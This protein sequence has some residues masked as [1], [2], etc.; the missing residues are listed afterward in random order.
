LDALMQI[1]KLKT[2]GIIGVLRR[3]ILLKLKII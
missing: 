2:K 1:L 3:G